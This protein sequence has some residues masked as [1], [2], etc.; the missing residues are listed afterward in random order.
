MKKIFFFVS[1]IAFSFASAQQNDFFDIQKHLQK[2]LAEEKLQKMKDRFIPANPQ[3]PT[4]HL[5]LY[6]PQAK[7][8]QTLSNGN[9]VYLLPMDNMPCIVPDKDRYAD[10]MFQTPKKFELFDK[11]QRNNRQQPGAIPNP[12]YP[13]KIIPDDSNK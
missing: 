12:V 11:L 1:I 6:P 13:L 7:L 4:I 2:K 3:N 9:K 8:S 5:I 10:N